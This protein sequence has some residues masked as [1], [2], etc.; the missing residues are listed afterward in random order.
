ME[1]NTDLFFVEDD[2]DFSFIMENAVQELKNEVS[3][4]IVDNGRAA[5]DILTYMAFKNLK[6]KLI[7]LDLNLP[8]I[9][10]IN[11]LKE[12]RDIPYFRYVPIVLFS[13][14][15]N[16]KDIKTALDFGAN[17]Y[18]AKPSGYLNLVICLQSFYDFWFVQNSTL[19]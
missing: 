5:L 1:N 3:I 18:V 14:S 9:S 16:P 6:P 13:T 2:T 4:R 12:I 15:E 8:G 10:G 7:L 17:A 19:D 11:L